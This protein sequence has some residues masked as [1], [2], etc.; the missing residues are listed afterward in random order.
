MY[1]Y[2]Y[3]YVIC[4]THFFLADE[5]L[6]IWEARKLHFGKAQGLPQV[7]RQGVWLRWLLLPRLLVE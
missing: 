7:D 5:D 3:L 1:I 6:F 4:E 2:I